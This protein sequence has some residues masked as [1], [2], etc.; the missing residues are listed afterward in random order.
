MPKAAEAA[1]SSSPVCREPCLKPA[2]GASK[3]DVARG[4]SKPAPAGAASIWAISVDPWE[5]KPAG[6]GS[7]LGS[8]Q[9]RVPPQTAEGGVNF[10]EGPPHP[11]GQGTAP[12]WARL[13][14]PVA[15]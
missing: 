4:M 9:G 5:L 12:S 6:G 7:L 10:T 8:P 15:E 11:P 14:S 13:V 1:W 3:W 2:V